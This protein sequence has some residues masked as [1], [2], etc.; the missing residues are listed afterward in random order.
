[1]SCLLCYT[2]QNISFSLSFL[3]QIRK[4]AVTAVLILVVYSFRNDICKVITIWLCL[5]S[6]LLLF[7]F[8]QVKSW[9]HDSSLRFIFQDTPVVGPHLRLAALRVLMLPQVSVFNVAIFPLIHLFLWMG[10]HQS[11][12]KG[13]KLCSS[14]IYFYSAKY[15]FV[16]DIKDV[17]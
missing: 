12:L 6:A 1:M 5:T 15:F 7:S 13:V 16:A 2:C 8:T 17:S 9:G 11:C 14:R 4:K 10:W 3:F